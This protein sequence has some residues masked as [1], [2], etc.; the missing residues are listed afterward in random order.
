MAGD[1]KTT[2]KTQGEWYADFGERMVKDYATTEEYPTVL[3]LD[4]K[5]E[6]V[7]S[8]VRDLICYARREGFDLQVPYQMASYLARA[9]LRPVAEPEGQTEEPEP[10]EIREYDTAA[11]SARAWE[12]DDPRR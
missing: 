11:T 12:A 8:I 7:T 5:I 3:S 1:A 2:A 6:I 4:M 9:A 10:A